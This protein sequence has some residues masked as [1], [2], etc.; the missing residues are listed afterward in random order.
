GT[1]RC[2]PLEMVDFSEAIDGRED[3]PPKDSRED[4]PPN[5]GRED[6]PAKE[7]REERLGYPGADTVENLD[8]LALKKGSWSRTFVVIFFH[9]E[10]RL[11]VLGLQ[12]LG[13][14]EFLSTY[15]ST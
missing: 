8:C 9:S 15:S 4:N 7:E 6:I 10:S 2:S 3:N 14:Y 5:E 1:V 13:F 12:F 11:A